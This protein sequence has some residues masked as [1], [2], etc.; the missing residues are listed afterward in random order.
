MPLPYIR[1]APFPIADHA[2]VYGSMTSSLRYRAY[3]SAAARPSGYRGYSYYA[4]APSG[5]GFRDVS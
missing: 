2:I 3:A 4:Y 1:K 5:R